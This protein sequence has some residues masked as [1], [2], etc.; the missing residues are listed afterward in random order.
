[1]LPILASLLLA[2]TPPAPSH[3]ILIFAG[4]K[5]DAEARAAVQKIAPL[6]EGWHVKP[7]R[8]FP[9]VL[10]SATVAG[11]KP[12]FVIAVFGACRLDDVP[13]RM[14]LEVAR[15]DLVTDEEN[16]G[17]GFSGSYYR[18][19]VWT[20]EAPA[21]VLQ[22]SATLSVAA[23]NA[24][25]TLW[26]LSWM[27]DGE[28]F[29]FLV[30]AAAAGPSGARTVLDGT[31]VYKAAGGDPFRCSLLSATASSPDVPGTPLSLRWMCAYPGGCIGHDRQ[32]VLEW[33]SVTGGKLARSFQKGQFA[34]SLCD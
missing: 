6:S 14:T 13:C 24:D 11:L 18:D 30:G 29:T 10:D 15:G 17:A 22:H 3:R 27:E 9:R 31:P 21:P 23:K 1:M 16:G 33:L 5:T 7:G 32:E 12:G 20:S 4:G 28:D 8:G 34:R 19:V 25:L 2:A 26:K